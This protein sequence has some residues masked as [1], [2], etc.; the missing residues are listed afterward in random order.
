MSWAQPQADLDLAFSV[1]QVQAAMDD[2][3]LAS[4]RH[5]SRPPSHEP[6][7]EG[8]YG[9]NHAE[10]HDAVDEEVRPACHVHLASSGSLTNFEGQ[11]LSLLTPCTATQQA[12][13][14]C[15]QHHAETGEDVRPA[16]SQKILA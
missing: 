12:V 10:A 15:G 9:P 2:A 14:I 8:V 3:S 16:V 7:A 13:G 11:T 4:S 6:S 5:P 1:L